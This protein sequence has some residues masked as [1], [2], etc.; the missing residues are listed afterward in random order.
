MQM[1]QH[2]RTLPLQQ[3]LAFQR[4]RHQ[5]AYD[6]F[7]GG[8]TIEDDDGQRRTYIMYSGGSDSEDEYVP[9]I[10]RIRINGNGGTGLHD[11]MAEGEH[12]LTDFFLFSVYFLRCHLKLLV[13]IAIIIYFKEV[14]QAQVESHG[15]YSTRRIG[16]RQRNMCT[17]TSSVYG[18]LEYQWNK[19]SPTDQ[20]TALVIEVD[21]SASL[22]LNP[23]MDMDTVADLT[24]LL[25]TEDH[26][27]AKFNSQAYLENGIS[28]AGDV[29]GYFPGALGISLC[30][31][32]A[33]LLTLALETLPR[34]ERNSINLNLSEAEKNMVVRANH[35]VCIILCTLL[36]VSS[37]S[38]SLL[39]EESCTTSFGISANGAKGNPNNENHNHLMEDALTMCAE[40]D[41]MNVM[42][43]SVI[44][45]SEPYVRVYSSF[46]TVLSII[47]IIGIAIKPDLNADR[48]SSDVTSLVPR[49]L[50]QMLGRAPRSGAAPGTR[51]GRERLT[52]NRQVLIDETN[53]NTNIGLAAEFT[54]RY[55]DV[56]RR[57]KITK[58]W[59]VLEK[60]TSPN[61]HEEERERCC[62]ICLDL[63]FP[64]A[65]DHKPSA[66][67]GG[68]GGE[69]GNTKNRSRSQ[70]EDPAATP[71]HANE[72][73]QAVDSSA[74][75]KPEQPN[76]DL[77]VPISSRSE[78]P[79][80]HEIV[81][82]LP[83]GH[84]Y[85]KPCILE[86]AFKNTTC[87]ECRASLDTG[88]PESAPHSPIVRPDYSTRRA[89]N[90][91]IEGESDRN[92]AAGGN[93]EYHDN[94]LNNDTD[95]V[96]DLESGRGGNQQRRG[97][98]GANV[99]DSTA[100]GT[101]T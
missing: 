16:F 42:L 98:D 33:A 18:V 20:K 84:Q 10:Q 63:L 50:R 75:M 64:N 2:I 43:A 34:T 49:A 4:Q 9:Q 79:C 97:T 14:T 3:Q 22:R 70:S 59:K 74:K 13:L 71:T 96:D 99:A 82:G 23:C 51:R 1:P 19:F 76:S 86:W 93:S 56:A 15:W 73:D 91:D 44:N 52:R 80:E 53:N 12:S 27:M 26:D 39:Q 58:D 32:A 46:T 55:S 24:S 11:R 40:I 85:H 62:T 95:V 36:F 5:E 37:A 61:I 31:Y 92:L 54:D 21:V 17:S 48:G 8:T 69:G 88:L 94:T 60:P 100:G 101:L 6:R 90:G 28:N 47:F 77:N 7:Y 35:V 38:Y 41:K 83:C 29:R 65:I 89:R 25:D 87:P 68:A 72:M 66:S 78:K 67:A 57:N 45:P 81:F 30:A